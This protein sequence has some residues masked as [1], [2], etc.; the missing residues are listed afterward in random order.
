MSPLYTPIKFHWNSFKTIQI[1]VFT[2]RIKAHTHI[3]SIVSTQTSIVLCSVFPCCTLTTPSHSVVVFSRI[4]WQLLKCH[5]FK[6]LVH[7]WSVWR[8]S[9]L[10]VCSEFSIYWVSFF[11]VSNQSISCP[12]IV[13]FLPVS[14]SSLHSLWQIPLFLSAPCTLQ[15][16]HGCGRPLPDSRTKAGFQLCLLLRWQRRTEMNEMRGRSK[17]VS[18]LK[19]QSCS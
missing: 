8:L 16:P 10:F 3:T 12:S 13:D 17:N 18:R 11:L 14:R 6:T 7:S 4:I 2:D 5:G 1:F 9:G 19:E 15:M